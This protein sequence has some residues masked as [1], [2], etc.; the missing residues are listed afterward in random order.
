MYMFILP[1]CH[2]E[3]VMY[4][5]FYEHA[6][7]CYKGFASLASSVVQ[8]NKSVACVAFIFAVIHTDV[9]CLAFTSA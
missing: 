3:A 8:I 5:L 7:K 1:S 9:G 6:A 4:P 2:Q